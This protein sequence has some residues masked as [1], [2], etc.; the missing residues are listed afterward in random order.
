MF[1]PWK[2]NV[3]AAA[4]RRVDGRSVRAGLPRHVGADPDLVTPTTTAELEATLAVRPA[5]RPPYSVLADTRSASYGLD[6]MPPWSTMLAAAL[7]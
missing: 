5:P 4:E 3:D 6:P 2:Y 7:S 1:S